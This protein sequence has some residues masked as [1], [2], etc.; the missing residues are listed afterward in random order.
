[1]RKEIIE[2]QCLSRQK[3]SSKEW[4]YVAAECEYWLSDCGLDEEERTALGKINNRALQKFRHCGRMKKTKPEKTCETNLKNCIRLQNRFP[5]QMLWPLR[6]LT[7]FFIDFNINK[8]KKVSLPGKPFLMPTILNRLN[9]ITD[10]LRNNHRIGVN[11][12]SGGQILFLI[13]AANDIVQ[14]SCR[15]VQRHVLIH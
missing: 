6:K 7:R 2:I 3:I 4:M 9:R 8:T 13:I 1:M 5:F 14:P 12:Q 11:P 15:T 10:N